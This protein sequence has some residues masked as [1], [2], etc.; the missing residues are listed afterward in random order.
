MKNQELIVSTGWLNINTECNNKCAWCYRTADLRLSPQQMSFSVAERMVDFFV[1][2]DIQ[3]LIFIGGEPTL[4]RNLHQLIKRA[5][6]GGIGEVTVVTNGRALKDEKLVLQYMDAGIDMFSVSIH[7]AFPE[8][9]N[10]ASQVDSWSETAK[11]IKNILSH[12]GKC[13]LNVI[14]GKQNVDDIPKSLPI[15]LSWGVESVIVSCSIPH[16]DGEEIIGENALDPKRFAQ[17]IEEITPISEKVIILHELPLCLIKKDTFLHLARENRL[18]YGCHVGVGRGL[19]VDVDGS[20]IP[21][22]SFPHMPIVKLIEN[23]KLIYSRNEFIEL[24][25]NNEDILSLRREANVFRSE[26]CSRCDLWQ[27]C[28]CGCPLTWGHFSPDDYIS[29]E[30]ISVSA[31]IIAD[32]S[33]KKYNP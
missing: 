17:L 30:L 20:V 10:M 8:I 26:I 28:N 4:Y 33:V 7:S 21:C 1:E 27:L 2:L 3:S 6:S 29:E 13:S 31:E 9:H 19:S 24:W 5:K 14:A 12:G 18:G 11:G 22:N 23:E 32:W 16:I 25:R 15:L